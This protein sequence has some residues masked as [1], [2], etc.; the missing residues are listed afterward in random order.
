LPLS[1]PSPG[2]NIACSSDSI[3][4]MVNASYFYCE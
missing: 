1:R 2:R 3:S 4:A